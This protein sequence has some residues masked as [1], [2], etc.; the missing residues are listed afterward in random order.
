MLEALLLHAKSV[1]ERVEIGKMMSC[2]GLTLMGKVFCFEYKDKMVFKLGKGYD[3]ESHGI[4]N[5]TF[6]S[7]FKN[8]GP[9][10]AWFEINKEDSHVF[11]ALTLI[12]LRVMNHDA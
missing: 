7:P 2:D 10:T 4:T 12:A 6:L 5:Y 11:E 8:K 9:M 1:D 3:I